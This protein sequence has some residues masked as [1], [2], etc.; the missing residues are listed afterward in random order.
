MGTPNP[1]ESQS[2]IFRSSVYCS[3]LYDPTW[4]DITNPQPRH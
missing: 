2:R 3:I 1:V 4:S